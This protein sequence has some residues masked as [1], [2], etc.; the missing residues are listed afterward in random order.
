MVDRSG[1]WQRCAQCAV[2]SRCS[3]SASR[4][5]LA[6]FCPIMCP[7]QGAQDLACAP[8]AGM[9]CLTGSCWQAHLDAAH[10]TDVDSGAQ[11]MDTYCRTPTIIIMVSYLGA[12]A[13]QTSFPQPENRRVP[14]HIPCL[15]S[16]ACG[17]DTAAPC[18]SRTTKS[19]WAVE[20]RAL[21][22]VRPHAQMGLFL[23]SR[24]AIEMYAQ[25]LG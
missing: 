15:C 1:Q 3:L 20:H 21:C 24:Y 17:I 16:P 4:Y 5:F 23:T 13:Q 11:L 25:I 10:A 12:V 7:Q 6:H 2:C 14:A 8:H 22:N 18:L 19:A 9:R